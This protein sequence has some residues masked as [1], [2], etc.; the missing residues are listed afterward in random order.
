MKHSREFYVEHGDTKAIVKKVSPTEFEL[1]WTSDP[2]TTT[3]ALTKSEAV[4]L[5]VALET[6]LDPKA[7][8]E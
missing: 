3:L 1:S 4:Q 5:I 2:G 8:G 6:V 7:G